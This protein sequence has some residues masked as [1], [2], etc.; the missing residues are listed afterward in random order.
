MAISPY[1]PEQLFEI[2]DRLVAVDVAHDF[3]RLRMCSAVGVRVIFTAALAALR[4]GNT[5]GIRR[6]SA[7]EY[8]QRVVLMLRQ[9]LSANPL[10]VLAVIATLALHLFAT[11]TSGLR[12]Q[13][14]HRFFGTRRSSLSKYRSR[15]LTSLRANRLELRGRPRRVAPAI[16]RVPRRG[17]TAVECGPRSN[18]WL[19]RPTAP[20]FRFRHCCPARASPPGPGVDGAVE[21]LQPNPPRRARGTP[22]PG[23]FKAA[24]PEVERGPVLHPNLR[25]LALHPQDESAVLKSKPPERRTEPHYDPAKRALG[26]WGVRKEVGFAKRLRTLIAE[27]YGELPDGPRWHVSCEYDPLQPCPSVRSSGWQANARLR[28]FVDFGEPGKGIGFETC[29]RMP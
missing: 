26:G 23:E 18:P 9:P 20:L 13:R 16:A 5:G 22:C 3:R 17:G 7:T 28:P 6:V 11:W 29:G 2:G 8:W 10:V 15:L 25:H 27:V 4:T 12:R 1:T 21:A 19:R 24:S 14:R